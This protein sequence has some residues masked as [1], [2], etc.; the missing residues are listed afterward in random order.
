MPVVQLAIVTPADGTVLV[1]QPSLRLLGE[2]R[3]TGHPPL[4]FSWYSSLHAA[5]GTDDVA[6]AGTGPSPLDL[7][8]A[9]GVGS[10]VVSLTAR[11]RAGTTAAD[12][13]QV[14]HGGMAGGPPGAPAPCVVH[15]LLAGLRAPAAGDVV[16]R[17]GTHL[18]AT[19]P[20][21]W[22]RPDYQVLNRVG[23]RWTFDPLGPP[24]GRPRAELAPPPG[25]LA[26]H[27]GPGQ[28]VVRYSGPLPPEL[29]D[30]PYRVGLLVH[31]LQQ[32][33]VADRSSVDVVLA[34]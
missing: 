4:F 13:R 26:L 31:D 24:P 11:D 8:T 2:V 3:S 32:P 14:L 6:L 18:E 12:L 22:D 10:H 9:V 15:V 30:G 25:D 29:G 28:P 16:H 20:L 5:T 1:G 19:A 7:T 34:A 17:A 23:Y 27:P 33:A 21:L